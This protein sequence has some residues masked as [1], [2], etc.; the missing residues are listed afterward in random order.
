LRFPGQYFEEETNLH[1]NHFRYYDPEIGRYITSDPIGLGGGT[2]IYSYVVGNALR[3]V[4][5]LGLVQ[6]LLL[7]V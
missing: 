6:P 7:L 4:D 3:Y 2:N 1:Y 5:P